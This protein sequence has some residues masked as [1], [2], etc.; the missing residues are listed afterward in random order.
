MRKLLLAVLAV[1]VVVVV[2]AGIL[3]TSR[4]RAISADLARRVEGQTGLQ[5]SS[6]GLPGISLWPRF[7]VSLGNVVIPAAKGAASAPLATVE[8]MRIVPV[9]GLLGLGEDGIVEIVLERPDI[10]LVVSAD[11]RAN[12]NYGAKSHEGEASGLALRIADGRITYLDERSGA[13]ARF[14]D[15]SSQ[16]ALAGPADELTAKGFFVWSDRRAA[17]TL[18]LKSPQRVAEDGSPADVTLQAPGFAF[19]FSGRAALAR[20]LEIDGQAEIKGTDLGLAASWFGAAL[21]PG[22]TGARFELAGAVETSDKGL[23]FKNAQVVLDDMHG[24]GAITMAQ[25]KGRPMVEAR[26]RAQTVDLTRYSAVTPA[27]AAAFLT[28]PWSSKPI[29]LSALRSFDADLDV[30]VHA[31]TQGAFR[32]GPARVTASLRNG[33]LDLK[34]GKAAYVGGTLDLALAIDSKAEP[35]AVRL[36]VN[37]DGLAADKALTAALGFGDVSGTLS[38]SLSVSAAGRSLAELIST[39][40]GQASLRIV[41]GAIRTVDLPGAFGKVTNAILGGWNRDERARTAFDALSASFV[42]AD[43]IAETGNLTLTSPALSFTGKGEVDLLRQAVDL[44]VDPQLALASTGTAPQQF[45]NF[46]VAIAVKGPWT[47]PRIYPDMPGILEDPASAYA[48]LRK[49]G[50]GSPD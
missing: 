47:G 29:D 31:F 6:S 45:A 11:G 3:L 10:N 16:A 26:I 32:T 12:W 48:A 7:S 42:V 27:P 38:P 1:A 34:L 8:T 37:G 40:K 9:N 2:A 5:V 36:S 14:T 41:S 17:F 46:P 44:K 39:L 35:P 18:F 20:S 49:L 24:E 50:L 33:H 25:G 19:Q 23:A 22:L 28:T 43:G 13:T 21:P 30:S 15:V 4:I